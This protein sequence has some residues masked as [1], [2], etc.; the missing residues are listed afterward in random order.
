MFRYKIHILLRF[1]ER[2]KKF[3]FKATSSDQMYL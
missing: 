2:F 3:S 1:V